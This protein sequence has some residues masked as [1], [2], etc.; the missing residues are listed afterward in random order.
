MAPFVHLG[1]DPAAGGGSSRVGWRFVVTES[2]RLALESDVMPV[3]AGRAGRGLTLRASL[4][5]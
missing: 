2:V 3:D 5:R 1:T 4:A